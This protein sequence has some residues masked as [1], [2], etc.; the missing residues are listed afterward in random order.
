M[1]DCRFKRNKKKCKIIKK[2]VK[3][4]KKIKKKV[5]K[6]YG[7][8]QKQ[9]QTINIF[10][11]KKTGKKK[12]KRNV[13]KQYPRLP[14]VN[15]AAASV[16]LI[17]NNYPEKTQDSYIAARHREEMNKQ[18]N[19]TIETMEMNKI[20]YGKNIANTK[21]MELIQETI[22]KL[23]ELIKEKEKRAKEAGKEAGIQAGI[24]AGIEQEKLRLKKSRSEAGKKGQQTKIKNL[25][26]KE[27]FLSWRNYSQAK[28]Q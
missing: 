16:P 14:K 21:N 3:K 10:L 17:I 7:Q 4:V 1:V 24:Q 15:A 9:S 2:K 8:R 26:K 28:N 19:I 5:K 6:K 12:Q 27:V 23:P 20:L 13:K 11:H 22:T 25:L 18:R